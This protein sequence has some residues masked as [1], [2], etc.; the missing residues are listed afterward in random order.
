MPCSSDTSAGAAGIDDEKFFEFL[1]QCLLD[2]KEHRH[3]KIRKKLIA[4]DVLQKNTL[5]ISQFQQFISGYTPRARKSLPAMLYRGAAATVKHQ[6][7][8]AVEVKVNLSCLALV[9]AVVEMSLLC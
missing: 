1:T 2:G 9:C 7:P 6:N 5:K 8:S 4:I 3:N